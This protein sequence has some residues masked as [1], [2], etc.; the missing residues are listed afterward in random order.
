MNTVRDRMAWGDMR[1]M[2]ADVEDLQGFTGLIN[3]K[4]PDQNWT[5]IFEPASASDCASSIPLP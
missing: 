5:G 2:K 1:M 3:G 4:G